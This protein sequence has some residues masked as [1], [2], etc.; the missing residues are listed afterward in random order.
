MAIATGK[1]SNSRKNEN[2]FPTD[3]QWGI[4][5]SA[6]QIEGSPHADWTTWDPDLERVPNITDHYNRYRQDLCLLKELGVNSYRFS[7]EWSRIQPQDGIWNEEAIAHYQDVINILRSYNIEPMVTLHHFTNPSWFIERSPWHRTASIEKFLRFTEKMASTLKNVRYWITFNEP[8]VIL[9]GGYLEGCTPPG[10]QDVPKSLHAL[11]NIFTCHGK[12]YDLIHNYVPDAQVS[13]SHNMSVFAPWKKWNPLDRALKK[14]ANF[15]YNHS[16]IDAFRTGNF[17]I[18]FPFSRPIEIEIPIKGKLDF[19]GVNYYTRIHLRFNPLKRMGVE[20][21]HL[22]IDGHGLTNIG[23]EIH[24]R[25]IEKVLRYASRLQVPLIITENGIATHD[26]E[27]KVNYMKRHVDML[28]RC[29]KNGLD[30]RGYYYWTLIDN[31][32]WLNGLD[33]R[34]GLYRV[35]FKTLQRHPTSAAAYYSY[36]IHSRSQL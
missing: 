16:I 2:V 6:F 27:K 25:G 5:T 30:I 35:D 9:L 21:R 28:E 34:F 24:P 13:L 1:K 20:L 26:S 32:E 18:K 22:D 4:A 11:K 19:F 3:F 29:L 10:I 7:I 33:T 14:T 8:Y 15:F 23:W 12:A 36:L 31:Y 17:V